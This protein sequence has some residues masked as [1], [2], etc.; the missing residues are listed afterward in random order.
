MS[1][2]QCV[3][4]HHPSTYLPSSQCISRV[5]LTRTHT[6]PTYLPSSYTTHQP[7]SAITHHPSTYLPSSHTTRQPT[8]RHHSD[9]HTLLLISPV[10]LSPQHT[11]AP[12]ITTITSVTE[13][14]C[15][16]GQRGQGSESLGS[17]RLGSPDGYLWDCQNKG[18]SIKPLNY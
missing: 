4:T 12:I 1:Q 15:C 8:F 14:P 2:K 5:S 3:S 13:I 7:T 10:T 9:I 18:V 16:R 17:N 6:P 11:V